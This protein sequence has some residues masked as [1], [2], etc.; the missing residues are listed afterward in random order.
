MDDVFIFED[1]RKYVS[2][3]DLDLFIKNSIGVS[4]N[5]C[6]Y[7]EKHVLFSFYFNG[8][9]CIDLKTIDNR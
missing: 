1:V 2:P 5:F 9:L 7:D 8:K 3:D 4:S 6:L